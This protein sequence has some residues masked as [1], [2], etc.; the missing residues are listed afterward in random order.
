[1]THY[2]RSLMDFFMVQ[3]SSLSGLFGKTKS[4]PGALLAAIGLLLL[5]PIP[6]MATQLKTVS[7][8]ITID[9]PLLDTLT[10]QSAFN[11]PD[12]TAR[13]LEAE[14]GCTTI[15]ISKPHWREENGLMRLETFVDLSAGKSYGGRCY[16]PVSWQG[17]TTIGQKPQID[18]QT[19]QL[20]FTPVDI[21]IHDLQHQPVK[22]GGIIS[23]LLKS[24]VF[25][26]LSQI[27]IDLA[28]PVADLKQVLL[29][30]FADQYQQRTEKIL[31]SMRP[32]RTLVT[33][34]YV[35]VNILMDTE[36]AA[37]DDV[38]DLAAAPLSK[39]EL[40]QFITAWE[41]WDA[42]LVHML[43]ALTEKPLTE[44]EQQV[45]LDVL[46]VTRHEFI[47]ELSQNPTG[48]DFVRK[49]FLWA[50]EQI[51]PIFRKH[52]S[53]ETS[54][55][56]LG[57]LAFFTA[58]DALAALDELGPALGIEIS[59]EGLIRLARLLG[60][61]PSG[62]LTYHPAAN[63]RLRQVLGLEPLPEPPIETQPPQPDSGGSGDGAK[64]S[65]R[66]QQLV[67]FLTAPRQVW[68]AEKREVNEKLKPWVAPK[69]GI[70]DYLERIK[71]L[72]QKTAVAVVTEKKLP[73]K[74][75]SLYQKLV[76]A[77]AWQESCFRQFHTQNRQLTYLLSYNRSSVG[78]MQINERV[79]RGI[80]DQ[81]RLRWDIHYNAL[82]GCEVLA[83]YFDR[84]ALKRWEQIKSLNPTQM[85]GVVY[86]MYN[87]GPG[88]FNKFLTRIQTGK[89]LLSDRL[90]KEKYTWVTK[91]QWASINQC[92]VS[93]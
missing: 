7:L 13:I 93:D 87:G 67:S 18:P 73:E 62:T 79:W 37:P 23:K 60:D 89:F 28:P 65:S 25:P 1:M 15:T 32:D 52:L 75:R 40:D 20:S 19:W 78:L 14:N 72:L 91:D 61:L 57:Y 53:K 70:E 48:E 58:S 51:A 56:S 36:S 39:D 34:E 76:Y 90:F 83:T 41:T 42:F 47:E 2:P 71:K 16:M 44:E 92:L 50:W 10:I 66:W 80:Y 33:P 46:L 8:P 45:L 86:A 12:Q 27:Q 26:Y 77:T 31:D 85:A 55:R 88:Q 17:Y 43:R 81:E 82:A 35:R 74:H 5:L 64:K 29:P 11:D 63:Q 6:A 54:A 68:A 59:R 84:Y 38:D 69:S 30:M 9:Y 21:D 49:Q 24:R 4:L 3:T 22:L